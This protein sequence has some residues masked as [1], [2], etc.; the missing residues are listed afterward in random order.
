MS[1]RN[2]YCPKEDKKG[3]IYGSKGIKGTREDLTRSRKAS[4]FPYKVGV[5][6]TSAKLDDRYMAVKASG[7]RLDQVTEWDGYVIVDYQR[8]RDYYNS[9]DR[10]RDVDLKGKAP[11]L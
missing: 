3:E 10:N 9:V 8:V 11:V 4:R 6:N 7:Y 1:T 5:G 2:R